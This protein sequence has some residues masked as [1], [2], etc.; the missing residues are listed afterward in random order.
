[1]KE[2]EEEF[3]IFIRFRQAWNPPCQQ[4]LSGRKPGSPSTEAPQTAAAAEAKARRLPTI[5]TPP[6]CPSSFVT[7]SAGPLLHLTAA[8][9]V[10]P[11]VMGEGL[12][13]YKEELGENSTV[14]LLIS[15]RS[16]CEMRPL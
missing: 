9:A 12:A 8:T 13:R 5:A 11:L 4:P 14:V 10:L 3:T 7:D 2:D 15:A 16:V 6:P 1:M